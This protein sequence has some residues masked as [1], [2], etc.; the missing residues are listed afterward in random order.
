MSGAMLALHGL[1]VSRGYAIG[2]VVV[3]GAAALEVSHYRVAP[4]DV[5]AE[6]ARLQAAIAT[7]RDELAQ[8]A[9][10]LPADVPRELGAFLQ[11]HSMILADSMISVEP[12]E[13]IR[14]R[15]YNAEWALTAQGQALGEQF[16][17][18][19]DE[20]MRER[21]NDIR[22]VIE[23][24][25]HALAGTDT[26]RTWRESTLTEHNDPLIVVAHDISPADMLKLRGGR[27]AAFATDLGG[28]TSH[29]AIV[30]RSMGVPAVVALGSAR[31]LMRDGD[32]VIVDGEAG[33]LLV[34][35]APR[36][37]DE[38][39]RR[40]SD[41]ALERADLATLK[42]VPAITLDGV[43]ITLCANIELPEEA[44]AAADAGADGIGLFR[45]E[46]LFMGRDTLPDEDEQY[47]AYALVVRTMGGKTVTIRTLDIG[48]DKTLDGEATV[49]TNPALGQRAIRYCLARPELFATQLRAILRASVHGKVQILIPMIAHLRE[50]RAAYAAIAS[51]RRDLDARGEAYATNIEVGA[52]V[53]VPAVAIAIE[54]FIEAFDFLSIGTNDLI[55][56]TLAID[57]TD[58]D[59][60]ALYDPLHPAVLRLIANSINAGARA[61]KRVSVCGEMA[62]D[63]ELTR[64]LLGLGLT[65]FSMHPTQLL[66]VKREILAA[67]SN[68]LRAKVATVLNRA[69]E[70]DLT[71]LNR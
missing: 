38:Y 62:G 18:M 61:G 67:H 4:E 35:P 21:G 39:R 56:Y 52:M 19:D 9:S 51:A 68:A 13:I 25:L 69:A 31:S 15:H 54:P 64:L 47:E 59:V 28:G 5:E 55:Q 63:T 12:V 16:A 26:K 65:H 50:V 53:E 42:D 2:R 27:F 34:N 20:Y 43:E 60:D 29:T 57:R 6:C 40:Q 46:F 66:D 30:A 37:L 7:A 71:L 1:G 48:A 23:R 10:D 49:A 44:Q 17:M 3:I 24:I 33:V 41:Y 32:T 45:S 36:V 11:V 22:Q 8:M 14:T 58:P 70:M